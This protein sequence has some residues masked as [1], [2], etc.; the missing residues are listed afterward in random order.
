MSAAS[1]AL[2]HPVGQQVVIQAVRILGEYIM[3][4]PRTVKEQQNFYEEALK[5]LQALEN[6]YQ[7]SG[8]NLPRREMPSTSE[9]AP[10]PSKNIGVACMPCTRA[11]LL[12]VSADLNEAV[13]FLADG[14]GLNNPEIRSRIDTAARE[15]LALERH[16]WTPAKV[17]KL[18]EAERKAVEKHLPRVRK[19]RQKLVNDL[20]TEEDLK[21]LAADAEELWNSFRDALTQVGQEEGEQDAG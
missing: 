19:L 8:Q 3:L 17:M 14:Q 12:A 20:N 2:N 7:P 15:L 6:E 11:H 21:S 5:K 18:P 10:K 4:R 9:L 13:R 1:A 16:D